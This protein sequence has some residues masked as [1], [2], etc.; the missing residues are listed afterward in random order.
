MQSFD[1]LFFESS[2]EK[3]HLD[4][5]SLQAIEQYVQKLKPE[6]AEEDSPEE[7]R[8]AFHVEHQAQAD[9]IA[10]WRRAEDITR[11]GWR[12]PFLVVWR[13]RKGGGN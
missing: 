8:E 4:D 7:V 2:N 3:K 1:G 6:S 9:D 12:N 10:R 5:F 11:W 13:G